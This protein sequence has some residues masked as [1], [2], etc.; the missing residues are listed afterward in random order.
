MRFVRPFAS[1]RARVVFKLLAA[2]GAVALGAVLV[3]HFAEHGWP[4]ADANLFG[5]VAAGGLF[6]GAFAFK[7]WGWQQLF[8][9]EG[10]PAALV[11][12][13]AG[14]AASVTG[15]A[16]PGRC[17]SLVRVA[18]V[19]RYPGQ[20]CGLSGVLISLFT[21]GL[22][23]NA[24][25]VPFAAVAAAVSAPTGLVRI[26][27]VVVALTGVLAAVAVLA[28]PRLSAIPR[29]VRLSVGRSVT[30]HAAPPRKAVKAW[31]LVAVSWSLRGA[32]LIVL[33]DAVSLGSISH[34]LVFLCASAAATALP[35]APQG[36]AA[37]AGAGAA[38][39]GA[40]GVGASEAVAFA[41]AAQA[42]LVL[43]GATIVALALVVH[44]SARLRLPRPAVALPS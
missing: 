43:A 30:A 20:R 34:A 3:R 6:V 26:A 19:R 28:L 7:A 18:V 11:L 15:L 37:Q 27:F 40:A 39:L 35:I 13:A 4:L 36:A 23:D 17:D 31:L 41:I 1:R 10:R 5:V 22:I 9:R 16:L 14:G 42:L 21:L 12:A 33:L 8:R 29:V 24:A 38:A 32:A 2:F 44:F 25:L